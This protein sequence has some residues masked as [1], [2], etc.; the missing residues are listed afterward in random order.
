MQSI[1]K[2][3]PRREAFDFEKER[4]AEGEGSKGG[5]QGPMEPT[6][7]LSPGS[8]MKARSHELCVQCRQERFDF[9]RGV[10][11]T[12]DVPCSQLSPPRHLCWFAVSR[13]EGAVAQ[14]STGCTRGTKWGPCS[15]DS[16]SD[17]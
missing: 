6:P 14:Q 7:A 3:L 1:R 12:W 2:R 5:K 9:T 16:L 8:L 17:G 10:G 13:V 11:T 4:G 15:V